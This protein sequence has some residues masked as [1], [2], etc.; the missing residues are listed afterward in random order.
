MKLLKN[1]AKF[2][3]FFGIGLSCASVI[4][5]SALPASAGFGGLLDRVDDINRKI[6]RTDRVIERSESNVGRIEDRLGIELES[7]EYEEDDPVG[8]AIAIYGEWYPDINAEE[9][10]IVNYLILQSA[11]GKLSSFDEFSSSEWF[12]TKSSQEQAQVSSTY[13]NLAQILELAQPEPNRFYA[14]AF[15]VNGGGTNCR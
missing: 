9:Q 4:S 3:I 7:S 6:D 10:E 2:A 5:M 13:M 14:F 1:K 8:N 15:C 12:M 11:Q